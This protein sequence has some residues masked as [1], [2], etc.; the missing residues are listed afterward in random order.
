MALFIQILIFDSKLAQQFLKYVD[1]MTT[2]DVQILYKKL[3][4]KI[5]FYT[6]T[7]ELPSAT[8]KYLIYVF[9]KKTTTLPSPSH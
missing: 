9:N 7:T 1:F 2:T 6:Y 5:T 8:T 3:V 4:Y